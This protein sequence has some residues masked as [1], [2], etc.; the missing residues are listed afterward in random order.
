MRQHREALLCDHFI[1]KKIMDLNI[2]KIFFGIDPVGTL[3]D[4]RGKRP[5]LPDGADI[6]GFICRKKMMVCHKRL[7]AVT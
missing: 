3:T 6:V 4:F 1:K 7:I 2:I 5:A